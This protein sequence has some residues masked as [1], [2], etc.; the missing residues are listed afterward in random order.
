M[1]DF[2]ETYDLNSAGR[3]IS[4]SIVRTV[5]SPLIL[6]CWIAVSTCASVAGPFGSGQP[7]PLVERALFWFPVIGLSIL[8][9][10][11][12]RTLAEHLGAKSGAFGAEALTVAIFTLAFTPMLWTI[13]AL[14]RP[15]AQARH[16]FGM[17]LFYVAAI[18]VAGVLL[19]RLALV[20]ETQAE[21][22]RLPPL[23]A[24]RD[25]PVRGEVLMLTARDHHVDIVTDRGREVVRM[26]LADAI[27]QLDG[28]DGMQVHRSHWVALK[29]V[30]GVVR[31]DGRL[32]LTT[33]FGAEVPV[34]RKYRPEVE[35]AGLA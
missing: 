5:R 24:R 26:R 28:A 7:A 2:S 29:A 12:A 4:G 10:V 6:C 21:A 9:A 25:A 3:E 8:V 20:G 16:G 34:G 30:D 14:F 33:R 35:S 1:R 31:R 11:A 32:F 27:A 23:L 19:R 15:P 17:L 22:R 13:L 18:A